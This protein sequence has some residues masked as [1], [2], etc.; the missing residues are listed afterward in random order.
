MSVQGM[1]SLQKSCPATPLLCV[2]EILLK[3]MSLIVTPEGIEGISHQSS[4]HHAIVL[5]YISFPS[6]IP[7]KAMVC[8]TM[9]QVATM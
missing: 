8:G 2:P 4:S 5:N 1:E 3:V 9:A 7:K 6:L